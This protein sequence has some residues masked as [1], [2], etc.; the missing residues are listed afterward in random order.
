[1]RPTIPLIIAAALVLALG[2]GMA[3]Q[4]TAKVVRNPKGVASNPAVEVGGYHVRR[5]ATPP[6]QYTLLLAPAGQ[7][8]TPGIS[9][10][11]ASQGS[12]LAAQSRW[13]RPCAIW[14]WSF[15]GSPSF[16]RFSPFGR[17][18]ARPPINWFLPPL[19]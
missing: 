6:I 16:H 5:G 9:P 10:W 3:S 7:W 11:S 4:A 18:P 15:F 2:Q 19:P 12:W 1:M 8:L 14:P 13:F 17:I